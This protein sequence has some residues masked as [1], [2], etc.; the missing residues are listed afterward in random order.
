MKRKIHTRG[1]NGGKNQR[2]QQPPISSSM[3]T[4][5]ATTSPPPKTAA[6]HVVAAAASPLTTILVR[7][8]LVEC[9]TYLDQ[10]SLREVCLLSTVFL[11][12]VRNDKR[13]ENHRILKVLEIRPSKNNEDDEGRLIR[14]IQQLYHH[15]DKLQLYREVR[16]IDGHKFECHLLSNRNIV[17]DTVE[18][19]YATKLAAKFQLNG[20]VSLVSIHSSSAPTSGPYVRV[21][22]V[23]AV[24]M[25]NLRE[26]NVSGSRID[27]FSLEKLSKP[28]SRLDKLT[29]DN[30]QPF[31]FVSANGKDMVY[32]KNLRE[33]NMDNSS[34]SVADITRA[35]M[36][37]LENSVS[38]YDDNSTI[39]LFHECGSTVLERVSIK[40]AMWYRHTGGYNA[41]HTVI[42]QTAL[43]KFIRNAPASLRYFG[44]DLSQANIEM[45]QSEEGG[46]GSEIEFG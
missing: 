12:I 25:P 4:T 20:V 37:D 34:F 1:G 18:E 29:Y 32:A 10:P 26:V 3:A 11:D 39:F 30:V 36:S 38:I 2:Q 6:P 45:L 5:R 28:C 8:L 13:M 43:I 41:K 23:L 27:G 42:P 35:K 14:L 46:R 7:P 16:I 15:R 17:Y 33:L 44:S 21:T 31:T 9:L 24:M 40:N 19:E 22:D